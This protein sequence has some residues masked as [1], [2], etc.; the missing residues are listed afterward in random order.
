MRKL[1]PSVLSFMLFMTPALAQNTNYTESIPVLGPGAL[2]CIGCVLREQIVGVSGMVSR[3]FKYAGQNWRC[4]GTDG[5]S[6]NSANYPAV[7]ILDLGPMG[8][9][10]GG[11]LA[12]LNVAS[13]PNLAQVTAAKPFDYPTCA[14]QGGDCER[15]FW[16]SKTPDHPEAVVQGDVLAWTVVQNGSNCTGQNEYAVDVN[17]GDL[18]LVETGGE[19]A[20]GIFID[21]PGGQLTPE[22]F[23]AFQKALLRG[24]MP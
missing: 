13:Y 3:I 19:L 5:N 22:Q 4:L 12:P 6:N 16:S 15:I 11:Y 21:P 7:A 18:S 24:I 10:N 23:Q 2:P 17:T 8:P 9:H 1:T 20:L 14:Q